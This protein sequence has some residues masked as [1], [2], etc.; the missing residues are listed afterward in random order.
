MT[1]R[2][3]KPQD[4]IDDAAKIGCEVA[5]IRAVAEVESRGGGFDPEGFPKTLFEGHW[6]YKLTK[7]AHASTHPT[8]CYP[9]WTKQYYGKSWRE[10]KE[11]L[12]Q[13]I[14]LDREAALMSASWGVFQIMGFNHGVCGYKNVQEFV[15]A[16]CRDENAHLEAFTNYVI[17]SGL[18]DELRAKDW[19]RFAYQY[20][21]PEYKK[22]DYGGK[23]RRA[24][25][26]HSQG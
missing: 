12:N 9:K 20:N 24:Y 16:M 13:A 8:L 23:L 15:N 17:N 10:E 21:G 18:A 5:C 22:N 7:G 19:D 4:F 2:L 6:F 26:K 11:R 14:Q 25:L 3:L 1:D